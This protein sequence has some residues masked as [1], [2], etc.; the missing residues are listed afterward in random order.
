MMDGVLNQ[1]GYFDSIEM[2]SFYGFMVYSQ[3]L[4]WAPSN[5]ENEPLKLFCLGAEGLY[6]PLIRTKLEL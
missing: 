5:I 4:R 3:H 6:R 2:S 1:H